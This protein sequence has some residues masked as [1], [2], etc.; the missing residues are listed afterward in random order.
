MVSPRVD[1]RQVEAKGIFSG[2]EVVRGHNWK[3]GDQDG[4]GENCSVLLFRD[5]PFL[6]LQEVQVKL[7][8]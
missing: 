2:A 3:Y 7:V 1:A 5:Y 4:E 8:E 6:F